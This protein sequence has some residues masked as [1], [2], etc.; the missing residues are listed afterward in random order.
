MTTDPLPVPR[1]QSCDRCYKQKVRCVTEKQDGASIAGKM[2]S[3]RFLVY[4]ARTPGQVATTAVRSRLWLLLSRLTAALAPRR[5]GRPKLRGGS[6]AQRPSKRARRVSFSSSSRPS[7]LLALFPG[8]E[9]EVDADVFPLHNGFGEDAINEVAAERQQMFGGLPVDA[10][11][12]DVA[13]W[14]GPQRIV[15][16]WS[17]E[18]LAATPQWP[19]DTRADGAPGGWQ[20]GPNHHFTQTTDIIHGLQYAGIDPWLPAVGITRPH[21]V[22]ILSEPLTCSHIPNYASSERQQHDFPVAV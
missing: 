21:P 11:N 3:H 17:G 10:I 8:G 22:P 20:G 1:R 12:I 4:G 19:L 15:P 18:S 6:S 13:I 14:T 16:S 2:S 5:S 7:G 9:P